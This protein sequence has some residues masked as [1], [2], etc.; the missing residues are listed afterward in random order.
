MLGGYW[1]Q[2]DLSHAALVSQAENLTRLRALQT[3]HALA[4]HSG[5]LFRKLDYLSLHLGEHW[6]REGSQGSRDALVRAHLALPDDALV[7]I[8]IADAGGD[9]STPPSARSSRSN[10]SATASRTSSTSVSI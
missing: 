1:L 6:L 4:L 3:A 7:G 2:L 8:D 9:C 10:S 5:A